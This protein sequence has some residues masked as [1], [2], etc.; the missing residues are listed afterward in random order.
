MAANYCGTELELFAQA[1][2]WKNY[3]YTLLRPYLGNTVLEVGAGIGGTTYFLAKPG[4]HDSWTC[5]EPDA[6]FTDILTEKIVSGHLPGYCSAVH[7][8]LQSFKSAILFDTVMFVDVLE[9]I[10]DDRGELERAISCLSNNGRL[11]I[12]SPAYNLLFSPFDRSVGHFRRYSKQ[13]LSALCPTRS[14]VLT[15]SYVD[16]FGFFASLANKLILHNHEISHQQV[17]FWDQFLVPLSMHFDRYLGSFFGKSILTVY[18]KET[19]D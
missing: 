7:G 9:H 11:I 15:S 5:L 6:R 19:S 16:S 12:F 17:K 14:A 3:L 1:T 8:T 10:E 18:K 13:M 2:N 4:A